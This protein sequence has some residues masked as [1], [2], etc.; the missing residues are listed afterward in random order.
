V[1]AVVMRRRDVSVDAEVQ[2][3]RKCVV[4]ARAKFDSLTQV[5]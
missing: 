3:L 2:K 1:C 5:C 4:D